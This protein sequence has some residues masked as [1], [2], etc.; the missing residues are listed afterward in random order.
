MISRGEVWDASIP[1]V[2][3]HP[4]VVVTRDAAIPLMTSVVCVLVT[5]TYRGHVAEVELGS[6]EGLGHDSVAN[7][8]NVFTLPKTVLKRRKGKLGQAKQ[9]E[10]GRALTIALGL[11]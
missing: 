10:L 6:D 2:G 4:V 9:A 8:D 3:S 5:T 1:G 11:D 7:C